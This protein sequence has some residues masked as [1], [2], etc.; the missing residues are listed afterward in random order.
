MGVV[1]CFTV[2][3]YGS[4][5]LSRGLLPTAK[6]L[7][8]FAEDSRV[9]KHPLLILGQNPPNFSACAEIQCSRQGVNAFDLKAKYTDRS[10]V[11]KIAVR[12]QVERTAKPML[13]EG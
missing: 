2:K 12:L 13:T 11:F 10:N 4:Y 1:L 9:C 7:W 5:D 6:L 3:D 8:I